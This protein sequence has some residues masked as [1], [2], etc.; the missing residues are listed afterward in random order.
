MRKKQNTP[1]R[2]LSFLITLILLL[3]SV[4][5]CVSLESEHSTEEANSSKE[6][7]FPRTMAL[8]SDIIDDPLSGYLMVRDFRYGVAERV[9]SGDAEQI[10]AMDSTRLVIS[11]DC[12]PLEARTGSIFS[13]KPYVSTAMDS[14]FLYDLNSEF[15][16]E[17]LNQLNAAEVLSW[18]LLDP[19]PQ[20]DF[21][22]FGLDQNAY[23]VS[24]FCDP[25]VASG[26]SP[27][28]NWEENFLI[29]G[30]MNANGARYVYSGLYDL[31]AEVKG[32][33]FTEAEEM[34]WYSGFVFQE[35]IANV[36]S[37]TFTVKGKTYEFRL[38]NRLSYAYYD[39]GDG[40]GKMASVKNG[41]IEQ[42]GTD[43]YFT[44]EQT[45]QRHRLYFLDR[46]ARLFYKPEEPSRPYYRCRGDNGDIIVTTHID[47]TNLTVYC[48]QHEGGWLDY[49]LTQ[50]EMDENGLWEEKTYTA[51][52]NFR[53]LYGHVLWTFIDGMADLSL[54]E[55]N[56]VADYLTSIQPV[57]TLRCDVEDNATVLNAEYFSENNQRHVVL[58]FYEYPKNEDQ[59]LLTIEVLE[60]ATA[61]PNPANADA[62]FLV[63]VSDVEDWEDLL[64]ALVI[65]QMLLPQA[66]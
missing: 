59:L 45:H 6:A 26:G 16:Y 10:F 34:E 52:D 48:P 42:V 9:E 40:K 62:R 46:S 36:T 39:C 44:D 5:G 54:F 29:I 57:I 30:G 3:G 60:S 37:M 11:F 2:C 51:V 14:N 27:R 8:L 43:Y 31:I 49:T 19:D 56:G 65:D 21:A 32:L 20:T 38:D 24:F 13:T 17:V 50:K 15:I 66:F 33:S 4:G 1:L 18:E 23:V 55:V 64:K 25:E 63:P 61:T 47:S 41:T 28:E 58:R 7:E 53:R 35:N 12:L 22:R